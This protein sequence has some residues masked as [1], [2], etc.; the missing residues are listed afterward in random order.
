MVPLIPPPLY[1]LS[2][3]PLP[4]GN[5]FL[6]LISL[7]IM[8]YKSIHGAANDKISSFNNRVVS[9]V[10]HCIQIYHIFFI[11]S[12]VDG[13]LG[14][15]HVFGLAASQSL[16]TSLYNPVNISHLL[17]IDKI[18][19]VTYPSSLFFHSSTFH[20]QSATPLF[21]ALSSLICIFSVIRVVLLCDFS[22]VESNEKDLHQ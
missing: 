9:H 14:C 22:K 15:F 4:T 19:M 21:F 3:L 16:F 1:C 17:T 8:P 10:F 18:W 5:H 7:S 20:S 13:H 2:H 6:W 12:S 11:R